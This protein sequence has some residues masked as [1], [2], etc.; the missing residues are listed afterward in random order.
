MASLSFHLSPHLHLYRIPGLESPFRFFDNRDVSPLR[1]MLAGDYPNGFKSSF[2]AEMNSGMSSPIRCL[3][4]FGSAYIYIHTYIHTCIHTGS[5]YT[6]T[7]IHT[8]I[9]TCIPT[10]KH[11]YI[12]ACVYTYIHPHRRQWSPLTRGQQGSGDFAKT[13]SNLTSLTAS[14]FTA[15]ATNVTT[16]A[17]IYMYVCVYVCMYVCMYRARLL[18]CVHTEIRVSGMPVNATR[19]VRGALSRLI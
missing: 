1:S 10:N 14:S 8:Y 7:H 19:P 2:G 13:L 3:N 5:P 4:C 12:H 11:A 9:H 18:I 15:A 17:Y 6:H 16:Q